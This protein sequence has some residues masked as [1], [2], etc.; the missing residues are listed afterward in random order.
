MPVKLRSPLHADEYYREQ[1]LYFERSV[2]RTMIPV[3][4]PYLR[5]HVD[6]ALELAGI[7]SGERI[8]EIGCGM[9]RYTLLLAQRGLE[10]EGLD[11][12]AVLLERLRAYNRGRFVI[13][14]HCGEIEDPRS[15]L[16]G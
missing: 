13:P 11:L 4:S 14:L 15:G 7:S 3:D 10:V 8:L 12:S 2:K 1:R 9:G 5:R 16:Q 6:Q